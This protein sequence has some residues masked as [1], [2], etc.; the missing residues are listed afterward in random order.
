MR[1]MDRQAAGNIYYRRPGDREWTLDRKVLGTRQDDRR[2]GK[3][4]RK[5][6]EVLVTADAALGAATPVVSSNRG[7]QYVRTPGVAR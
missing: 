2:V 1:R 7:L 6:L 5:G 4:Q 3:L